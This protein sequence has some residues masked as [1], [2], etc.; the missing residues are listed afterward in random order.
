MVK[1]YLII[2]L[3]TGKIKEESTGSFGGPIDSNK[4]PNLDSNGQ[5]TLAMMPDGVGPDT[6]TAIAYE[7]LEAYDFVNFF[8]DNGTVKVRKAIASL[9]D[10]EAHGFVKENFNAND[11]A[12][13]YLN[14][15][16]IIIADSTDVGKP[17]YLSATIYGKYSLKNPTIS[18]HY[19]QKIG[20][21]IGINL[22]DVEIFQ[23]IELV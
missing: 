20:T 14:G 9:S 7:D 18:G 12:T 10:H 13:I 21:V 5:L 1:K 3:S 11:I 19:N 8:N 23:S 2:D 16:A 17:V 4:I 6:K 15:T 22:M